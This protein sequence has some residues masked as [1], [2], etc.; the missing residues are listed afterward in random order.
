MWVEW[1]VPLAIFLMVGALYL[2]GAPIT[3]HGGGGVRQLGGVLASLVL[4]LVA[5]GVLRTVLGGPVGA[6]L[7]IVFATI[8]AT[9]ALPWICRLG[10]LVFGVK[11]RSAEP[12]HGGAH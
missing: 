11:I 5:W 1:L 7:A 2:G 9:I 10:F 4:Y 3:F 6:I 12:S 8:V